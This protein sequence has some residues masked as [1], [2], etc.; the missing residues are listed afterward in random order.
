[1][2]GTNFFFFMSQYI[3]VSAL[4]IFIM[5]SLG[6]GGLEAGLAQFFAAHWQGNALMPSTSGV[7]F[8]QRRLPF[9]SS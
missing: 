2:S 6:G 5:E 7:C 8:L 1:M 4:P 9:S 3:M